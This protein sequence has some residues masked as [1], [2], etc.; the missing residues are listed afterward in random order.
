MRASEAVQF[1]AEP[2]FDDSCQLMRLEVEHGNLSRFG[3]S[4]GR[5]STFAVKIRQVMMVCS[6][7]RW[8]VIGTKGLPI[9]SV[10]AESWS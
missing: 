9:H 7:L 4:L 10:V 2:Y 8:V 5:Y 1:I 6:A 3:T